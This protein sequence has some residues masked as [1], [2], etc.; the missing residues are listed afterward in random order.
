MRAPGLLLLTACGSAAPRTAPR[1]GELHG[2]TCTIAGTHTRVATT[3]AASAS[4]PSRR[5]PRL[6]RCPDAARCDPGHP[7]LRGPRDL[8][9]RRRPRVS[10]PRPA[11]RRRRQR[12]R[13]DRCRRARHRD[14]SGTERRRAGRARRAP[15]GQARA[16]RPARGPRPLPCGA[17]YSLTGFISTGPGFTPWR[18]FCSAR[19]ASASASLSRI[20]RLISSTTPRLRR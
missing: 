4:P 19:R 12:R 20:A 11:V 9:P 18:S 17:D 7:V 2:A 14:R 3:S 1:I 13:R 6:G 10:A 8:L 15:A 16:V 5:A